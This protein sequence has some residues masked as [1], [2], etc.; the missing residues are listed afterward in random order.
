MWEK[1]VRNRAKIEGL[2]ARGISWEVIFS[3]VVAS[4]RVLA[5]ATHPEEKTEGLLVVQLNVCSAQYHKQKENN[6]NL[7]R[8]GTT[9][10]VEKKLFM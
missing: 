3:R 6:N 2:D 8:T 9:N 7:T 5:H 1:Q 10:K 4:A